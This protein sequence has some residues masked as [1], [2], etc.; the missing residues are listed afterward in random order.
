MV[1]PPAEPNCGCRVAEKG[2]SDSHLLLVFQ[3]RPRSYIEGTETEI[4]ESTCCI[5]RSGDLVT[6]AAAEIKKEA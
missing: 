6:H 2:C 3:L 1:G 4:W 5:F